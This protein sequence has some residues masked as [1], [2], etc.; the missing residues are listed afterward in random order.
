LEEKSS[1][2]PKRRYTQKPKPTNLRDKNDAFRQRIGKKVEA[3][4]RAQRAAK[5]TSKLPPDLSSLNLK[6]PLAFTLRPTTS[7]VKRLPFSTISNGLSV[8]EL[9]YRLQ[10]S[11]E[12]QTVPLL[13]HFG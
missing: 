4:Y 2:P 13:F 12:M 3:D 7:V 8:S 10:E 6:T 5:F 9:Y 1:D 11:S